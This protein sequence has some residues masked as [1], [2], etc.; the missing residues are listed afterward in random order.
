M[1]EIEMPKKQREP[2]QK[3]ETSP[4][5][6]S[7]KSNPNVVAQ[8]PRAYDW[9]PLF[10]HLNLLESEYDSLTD[11]AWL[12]EYVEDSAGFARSFS[13]E[14]IGRV[15]K[16]RREIE[17]ENYTEALSDLNKVWEHDESIREVNQHL[18]RLR[19][20]RQHA[21][22]GGKAA[23]PKLEKRHQLIRSEYQRVVEEHP[24]LSKSR[25][26]ELVR[27]ILMKQP[28]TKAGLSEKTI[29]RALRP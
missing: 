9:S 14:L 3:K 1:S 26:I 24:K 5:K 17:N 27:Q 19:K 15:R 21:S 29:R 16:L 13:S 22:L 18:A 2:G 23:R 20:T 6:R 28:G 8:A 7:L 12:P 4:V 10:K 11:P 25:Q